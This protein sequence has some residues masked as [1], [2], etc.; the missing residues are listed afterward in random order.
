MT[1][2]RY[3]RLLSE[4]FPNAQAVITELINLRAI[5]SLPK[6]TEHFVSDLHGASMAFIHMIKNASGVVR[7]KVDEVYGDT[8]AEEEK[9]ALCALIY[10]PDERIEIIKRF[11]T[12]EQVD[13]IISLNSQICELKTLE[14]WYRTR[15][16]QVVDIARAVTIKYSRSKVEKL[17]LPQYAYIIRELLHESRLEQ[18][19]RQTYYNAII[20]AIIETGCADQLIIVIS[21]LIHSL[22]IDTLHIVGDIFDRGSGAAKILDVLSTVRDYDI[23]WGNHD[24]EWMGAMAGNWALIATVLRVSIR[25]ANIETLEEGYGINLLPLANF[26]M[27][28]YGDD[29]CTIWQTKDFENNPRLT[30]SAQLMAKMHKAISII[31]FKLEGQTVLRHPEWHMDHRA[32]L[33]KID[34]KAGTITLEGKTYPLTDTN[35]PTIDS[36]QPYELSQYELDL[37]NQLARSFRKSEK[38][39]RHLRLLYEHGSLYLVRNGFLLYHAAI[40]LNADGSFSE[41]EVFG[42]RVSGKALMDRTDEIIRQA[43]YGVGQT[44]QNALD[45]LLYLWEGEF[46]PLYNKDKMTTFERYFIADKAPQEE[47]KGAYFTLSDDEK[48]CEAILKEFGLDPTTGRII[49]GHVPVR[50]IK[51]ETPIRA[52]GKRF[53]ID[54]GFSKPYQEKTGIA[55]YTL[56]YNSHGIQ[57]VEHESFE[58]REQAILSGSDI[59]SRTLLQDFSGQRMHIKDT[60]KGK[61]LLEQINSLEQ[62]LQAYR[63]GTLRERLS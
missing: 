33:D 28:V 7:R 57:L 15:L 21:Y 53:V 34:F 12:G 23:Q 62:L 2:E 30:R 1:D 39:Q 10:Y 49:N 6:G 4:K 8:M 14:D 48:V 16:H 26:A 50:T 18:K 24:I 13:G 25:Y 59:H 5:L 11:Y 17:L 9:R 60:D 42:K 35:L 41:A 37:M 46:S 43:Y 58:S 56:I 32:L 31:Q 27:T 29:P 40:P 38:M 19:D 54:G 63:S 36:E 51:G 22:T 3:L 45:Y 55:G 52:N 47:K 61:E 44:K 20:D